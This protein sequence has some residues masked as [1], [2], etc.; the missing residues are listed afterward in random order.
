[1]EPADH[2]DT[3][4]ASEVFDVDQAMRTTLAIKESSFVPLKKYFTLSGGEKT[5][6]RLLYASEI[7]DV[8]AQLQHMDEHAAEMANSETGDKLKN[9]LEDLE[10]S[11]ERLVT[12]VATLR[13]RVGRH[14]T[15]P[16]ELHQK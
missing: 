2:Y 12:A 4:C 9:A 8:I 14:I 7:M 13:H 3:G 11:L 15:R 1:V 6:P 5:M 16:V 10:T